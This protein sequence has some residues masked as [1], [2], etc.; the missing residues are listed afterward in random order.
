MVSGSEVG[1]LTPSPAPPT[2]RPW[3]VSSR[4]LDDSDAF[5]EWANE[6]DYEMLDLVRVCEECGCEG[7]E[8]GSGGRVRMEDR[9]R[10]RSFMTI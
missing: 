9:R 2:S 7:S 3:R 4:W 8:V 1:G 5:N 10:R 6:E